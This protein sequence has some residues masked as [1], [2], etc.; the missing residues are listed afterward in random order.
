MALFVFQDDRSHEENT[1]NAHMTSSTDEAT[2][3][4]PVNEQDDQSSTRQMGA[5]V[6]DRTPEEAGY[7]YGV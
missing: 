1:M 3:Q 4:E 7:G 6:D 5:E 2:R